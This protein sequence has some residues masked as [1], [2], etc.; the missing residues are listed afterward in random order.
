[1]EGNACPARPLVLGV[2]PRSAWLAPPVLG[3]VPR[4]VRLAPPVLGAVLRSAWQVPPIPR[5]MP[6]DFGSVRTCSI[7]ATSTR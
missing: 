7:S 1:M 3:V 6:R 4:S 5:T 2:V